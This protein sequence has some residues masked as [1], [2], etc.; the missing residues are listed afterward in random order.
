MIG[1]ITQKNGF[2]LFSTQITFEEPKGWNGELLVIGKAS[3]IPKSIMEAAPMGLAGVTNVPYPVSRGW[4]KEATISRT[5]QQS[6]LGQGI[7]ALM[8]FE[9][10]YKR[11]RTLILLAAESSEDLLTLGDAML[12]SEIQGRLTGDV[13]LIELTPPKYK[14]SAMS[15]GKK[16]STGDKGEVSLID[17]IL[18]EYVYVFYALAA[19]LIIALAIF[20]YRTLRRYRAKRTGEDQK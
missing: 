19:G 16:Y 12:E 5:R 7:G 14:V 3:S 10:I 6:G 8:E 1:M 11:G 2:P 15:V 9:S 18:H 20:G 17:S 13:A 4:D